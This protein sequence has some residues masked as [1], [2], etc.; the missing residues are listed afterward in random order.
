MHN[1]LDPGEYSINIYSDAVCQAPGK[2]EDT[3][4]GLSVSVLL[5]GRR[6]RASLESRDLPLLTPASPGRE[7][8][9]GVYAVF[10]ST[11]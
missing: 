6:G 1:G 5:L 8:G 11:A 10:H 9:K 4:F 7:M 2:G 3:F